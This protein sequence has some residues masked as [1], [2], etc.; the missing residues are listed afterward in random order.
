[1]LYKVKV[2]GSRI[3][4]EGSRKCF[5]FFFSY[6]L[7]RV[8]ACQGMSSQS[9]RSH[10]HP[11]L[12]QKSRK[13]LEWRAVEIYVRPHPLGR[14]NTILKAHSR[15]L[16]VHGILSTRTRMSRSSTRYCWYAGNFT[17][18]F[19]L[20]YSRVPSYFEF[21]PEK[22]DRRTMETWAEGLLPYQRASVRAVEPFWYLYYKYLLRFSMKPLQWLF[23]NL[24]RI[25]VP[26]TII[27]SED[28]YLVVM[29]SLQRNSL[30]YVDTR[31]RRRET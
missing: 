19:A 21:T 9:S 31:I 27:D 4:G 24:Q 26:M 30:L 15:P 25:V 13:P 3:E 16:S 10:T 18:T 28:M 22:V 12:A 7:C 17:T 11:K 20:T 1:M 8:P 2:G 23:P 6:F 14:H 5:L 29:G